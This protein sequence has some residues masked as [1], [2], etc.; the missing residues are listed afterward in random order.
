MRRTQRVAVIAATRTGRKRVG[1][2]SVEKPF[3]A[4]VEVY[5][6]GELD[7]LP[8]VSLRAAKRLGYPAAEGSRREKM[9][10]A[11]GGRVRG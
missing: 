10:L 2:L 11:A 8:A 7:E 3:P 4:G 6:A 5:A 1:T 9:V